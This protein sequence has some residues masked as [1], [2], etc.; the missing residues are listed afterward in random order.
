MPNEWVVLEIMYAF[1]GLAMKVSEGFAS[2]FGT[3]K[4][5][6]KKVEE[7]LMIDRAS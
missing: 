2:L 5:K 1:R 3:F 4:K 7:A 6:K